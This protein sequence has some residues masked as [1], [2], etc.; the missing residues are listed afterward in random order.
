MADD[1]SIP[2]AGGARTA[3]TRSYRSRRSGSGIDPGSRILM[4][5]AS[6]LALVLVGGM[7]VWSLTGHRPAAGIPTIEADSRPLRVKPDNPGGMSVSMF[8]DIAPSGTEAA[9]DL[10]PAAEKPDPQALLAQRQAGAAPPITSTPPVATPAS[11][12]AAPIAALPA[13][14]PAARPAPA[15]IMVQLAA[16]S[17]EAGASS[18]WQRL[19]RKLPDLLGSRQPVMQRADQGGKPIWRV[20]TGGFSDV[21]DAT[22]FCK[23]VREKGAGC[24]LASF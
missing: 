14:V 13:V 19:A 16:V 11:M 1:I 10:A 15:G 21:A 12:D 3:Y 18:E 9:G 4:L 22:Q 24:A 17:S 7:A 2:S 8:T 23:R 20:R 6:G 5:A